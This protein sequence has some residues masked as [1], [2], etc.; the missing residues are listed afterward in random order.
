M[1]HLAKVVLLWH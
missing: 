1:E